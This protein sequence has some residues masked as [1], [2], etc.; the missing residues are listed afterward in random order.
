MDK[1]YPDLGVGIEE[2]GFPCIR[3]LEYHEDRDIEDPPQDKNECKDYAINK[4]TE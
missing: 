3:Y 1:F 2:D 4:L